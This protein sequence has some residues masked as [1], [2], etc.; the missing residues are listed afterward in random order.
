MAIDVIESKD[1][2]PLN[3][4]EGDVRIED[5]S[6]DD[7]VGFDEYSITSYGADFDVEGIV[8]RLGRGDIEIPEFQR[9]YVW[10]KPQASKFVESLL[11]GLPVPG[12]FLYRED[13][14]RKLTVIDGQQ[15]ILTLDYF[16]GGA[17]GDGKPFQLRGLETRFNK[18]VYN[19]LENED[20]RKLDDSII[21]ATIIRQEKPED[22]GSSKYSIFERLNTGGTRLAPQ[23][24]RS[25]IYPGAFCELLTE[26]NNN[27]S[28]RKLFGNPHRRK[29]DEELILRFFALFYEAKNYFRPMA[30]F[31]NEFMEK[32]RNLECQR[33]R[34]MECVFD[35]TVSTILEKISIRAFKPQTAVNAAVLDA[36]MVGVATRLQSG[37][38]LKSLESRYKSLLGN[39][40]FD[41]SVSEGTS[42]GERVRQRIKLAINAFAEA[43]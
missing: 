14:T 20:R 40:E 21:H 42:Q 27:E 9:R 26:L 37:E 15:R 10:T 2:S 30:K 33:Q 6:V 43:E 34:E 38:I 25:A 4:D 1:L 16:Y 39:P 23:E 7:S 17:F 3:A 36:I 35:R 31:L 24:I 41:S 18:A 8:R 22:G 13:N 11:L 28:W 12:I 19:D 5:D 32:N 29:R